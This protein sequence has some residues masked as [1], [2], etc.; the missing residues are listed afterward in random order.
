[1]QPYT[2]STLL[3]A[4]DIAA[5]YGAL[6]QVEA[7]ALAGSLTTQQ[8]ED[9]SDIDLYVYYQTD[10][11]LADRK[12]IAECSA[13]RSELNNRFWEPGDEWIDA[14]SGTTV[15]VMFRHTHWIEHQLA[16]VLVQHEASV[17]YTTCFWH[18][19][20]TSRC[21]YDKNTW[22]AGL[23]RNATQP[24][25][26]ALRN[27]IIAKNYPILRDNLSS[28]FHQIENAIRRHDRVSLNHRVTAVLASYFDILFA[29]NRMPHP[30]EKRIV[31]IAQTQCKILPENMHQQ[32]TDLITAVATPA[33]II[34]AFNALMNGL[35]AVLEQ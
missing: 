21:L 12:A 11:S 16:R 26:D 25:P 3:L 8:A 23:Q 30:G 13:S 35:D 5:R 9:D 7:V 24:Y 1:M 20:L 32:I 10:I 19:V 4:S 14:A 22:F 34:N 6:P 31:H 2:Q 18:N 29:I 28:Y 27:N 15:D 17:G 33:D